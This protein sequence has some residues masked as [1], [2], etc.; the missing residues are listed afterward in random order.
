MAMSRASYARRVSFVDAHSHLPLDTDAALA[1]V[2]KVGVRIV[3]ICVD[4]P[5]LGGLDAQRGWYR[6]LLQRHPERFAWVTSF[7]LDGFGTDGWA[8]RA[9]AQLDADFADG[10]CG[11][12]VWKN[13]GME[14]RDP[15]TGAFV[16]CDDERFD[17]IY[18]HL[19][20]AGRPLLMHI[21][22]PLACWQSLDAMRAAKSP[23]LA[24][25]EACPQWHW[26]GRAGV[27]SHARLI[28][29]R[30]A[31][32]EKHPGLAVVGA[33]YGSLEFDVGE[34][35]AR[36]R[37]F[38]NFVVDTS[39]RL[40][41]IAIQAAADR[42]GVRRLFQEFSTRI[43]WGLDWV[44]TRPASALADGEAADLLARVA[45]AYA[46]ERRFFL[47]DDPAGEPRGLGLDDAIVR[48]LFND[49]ARRVYG[50]FTD[51]ELI[52]DRSTA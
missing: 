11:C 43:L 26:H 27:P 7:S 35:A 32:C 24:Y 52:S 14:L 13:V 45:A 28:A 46:E 50:V 9:I 30:D 2:E 39:A 1:A 16:F 8:E 37:R 48:R 19:A 15:A 47:S 31:V 36:L 25:Y 34:V 18:A 3:N 4:S 51:A 44:Q 5:Q 42:E 21:G 6:D 40:G 33:H 23:H 12:K 10:A 38:P 41:D 29:S 17:A 22:E 49:N 20:A